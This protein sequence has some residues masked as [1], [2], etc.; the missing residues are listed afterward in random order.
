[1]QQKGFTL[2]E[3]IIVIVILGILAVTAAPKYMDF[4]SDAKAALLDGAKAALLGGA[5]LVYA[6]ATMQGLNKD[7]TATVD[8]D[9]D[10]VGDIAVRYGYPNVTST[11]L[12]QFV[13]LDF[14]TTETDDVDWYAEYP[15]DFSSVYFSPS[16][17]TIS[18]S[19]YVRYIRATG[20]NSPASVVVEVSGC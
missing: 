1:M 6:K 9:G 13:D 4:Q 5:N 3:L 15:S 14:S 20:I 17:M 8:L 7:A 18:D 12:K 2:I 10:G 19:C 16:G 11:N